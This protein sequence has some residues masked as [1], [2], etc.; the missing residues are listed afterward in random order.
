MFKACRACG[1]EFQ[2]E[3]FVFRVVGVGETL[4]IKGFLR[5]VGRIH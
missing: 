1:L 3:G 5:F 2:V 4:D